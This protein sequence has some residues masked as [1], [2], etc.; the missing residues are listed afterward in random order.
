LESLGEGTHTLRAVFDDGEAEVTFQIV[1]QNNTPATGDQNQPA[2]W[3][4]LMITALFVATI[5]ILL[6]TRKHNH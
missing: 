3:I 5:T 4:V 6:S 2:L 1:K